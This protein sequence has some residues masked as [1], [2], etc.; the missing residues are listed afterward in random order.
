MEH[1]INVDVRGKIAKSDGTP[2]IC[3]N[4]DFIIN[5]MFDEDWDEYDIKTARFVWGVNYQDVV[6]T[7]NQCAVP[8][9]SNTYKIQ[10][11]VFAGDLETTTAAWIPARKGI[12]CGTGYPDPPDVDVYN[13]IMAMLN[14]MNLTSGYDPFVAFNTTVPVAV[15][16]SVELTFVGTWGGSD[17]D[18]LTYSIVQNYNTAKVFIDGVEYTLP[19][20]MGEDIS[21]TLTERWFIIG[22]RKW[23]DPKTPPFAF[24]GYE[25]NEFSMFTC[26]D[27]KP[28]TVSVYLMNQSVVLTS[29]GGKA[30][31]LVVSDSGVLSTEAYE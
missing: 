20:L 10:L 26:T 3:G 15:A 17:V 11:G 31:K 12:L 29:E 22:D 7:G 13:Q 14:S 25:G 18:W 19:I 27:K 8:V 23:T 21:E 9:I 5:F 1:I 6:F 2:Y 28:H 4:S 30:F 16:E 24:M